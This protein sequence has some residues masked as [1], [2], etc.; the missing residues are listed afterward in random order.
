MLFLLNGMLASAEAEKEAICDVTEEAISPERVEEAVIAGS[1]ENLKGVRTELLRR[2]SSS[3]EEKRSGDRYMLAYVNWRMTQ[4]IGDDS[5]KERKRLLKE[6]QRGLEER[7]EEAPGDAE[8]HALRGTVIGERIRGFFGGMFL[9]PKASKSLERA[10][11]LDPENPRIALQRG[12]GYFHTPK[13]F[14]GGLEKAEGELRRARELFRSEPLE[15]QWPNWGRIDVLGWL[16][17]ALAGVGKQDEA[18]AHYEEALA[19]EPTHTWIREELLPALERG[20]SEQ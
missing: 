11:E 17:Q 2:M 1:I 16:G 19:I 3:E 14:G 10:Y 8:T 12:V 13:A 20:S 7:I 15:K 9:G 4:L 6:A 18:R 5:R